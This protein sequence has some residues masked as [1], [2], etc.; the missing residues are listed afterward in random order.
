MK[1]GILPRPQQGPSESSLTFNWPVKTFTEVLRI[2]SSAFLLCALV[3]TFSVS[4]VRGNE[5]KVRQKF[6]INHP[7]CRISHKV[8]TNEFLCFNQVG[9]YKV[10]RVLCSPWTSKR[11]VTQKTKTLTDNSII[12]KLGENS[13][14]KFDSF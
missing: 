3:H 12:Q 6:R 13:P 4:F 9:N 10:L 1:S 2:Y 7:V 5:L 11:G 14:Y 8:V